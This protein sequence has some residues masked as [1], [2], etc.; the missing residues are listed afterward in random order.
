M[1]GDFIK[2][3]TRRKGKREEEKRDRSRREVERGVRTKEKEK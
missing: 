1:D 3:N 2:M